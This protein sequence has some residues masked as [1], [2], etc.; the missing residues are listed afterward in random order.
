MPTNTSR[1]PGPRTSGTAESTA[2]AYCAG[3]TGRG[4]VRIGAVYSV[5]Y[6]GWAFSP[7]MRATAWFAAIAASEKPIVIS[8]ILPS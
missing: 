2:Q 5:E 6:F 7:R 1:T 3:Q 8:V 4:Q